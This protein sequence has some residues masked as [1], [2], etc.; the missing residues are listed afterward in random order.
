MSLSTSAGLPPL[1]AAA[2][3]PLRLELLEA[4]LAT[5][6]GVPHSATPLLAGPSA[7]VRYHLD[8]LCR[9][10]LLVATSDVGGGEGTPSEYAA[11]PDTQRL[12]EALAVLA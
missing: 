1:L 3:H 9:A 7:H 12:I 5:R 4:A 11:T 6:R 8:I 2:C 10:G